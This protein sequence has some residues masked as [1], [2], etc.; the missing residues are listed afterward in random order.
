MRFLHDN[1]K[2][3]KGFT[4]IETVIGV[5]VFAIISL[6]IYQAYVSLFTLAADN[7]YTVL[8]L[9]LAN[10]EF[11]IARNLPFANVGE[12]SGIPSGSI[13]HVQNITNGGIPFVVTTTIRNIDIPFNGVQSIYPSPDSKLVEVQVGCPTC[14]NFSPVDLVTN[15]APKNLESATTTGA[16]FI[17]VFDANGIAVAGASVHVVDSKVSPSIVVDDTT[18]NTGM[19]EI[20]GAPP[21]VNAYNVTVSKT[22]YSSAKTYP[23]GGNGNP[24]PTQPDATVVVQQVTKISFSIDKLSTMSFQSVTPE[25]AS[26]GPVNFN[27]TGAKLI[28]ASLPKYS[29]NL[30]TGSGGSLNLSS[31]EWDSYTVAD[32]DSTYNIIGV[33]PLNPIA[34]NPNSSLSVMLVVQPKNPKSLLV[35]VKDSSTGLPITGATVTATSSGSYSNTQITGR[36]YLTQTDWSGGSGQDIFSNSAEYFSDDGNVEV[37]NPAGDIK[38]KKTS[39]YY[40]TTTVLESST[41]DTGSASNFY[42]LVWA[43]TSQPPQTGANS[44]KLQFATATSS[45]PSSWNYSGPDGTAGSYYTTANTVLNANNNGNR[46]ARYKVFLSTQN[47]TS[48]PDISDISFTFSSLCTPPGQVVFSGLSSGTY[49]ISVSHSGYSTSTASTSVSSNWT[50]DVVNLAP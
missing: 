40:A 48:T 4:L 43:P 19:L 28:G 2:L 34:L 35:T 29:Q 16:L 17:Q 31:M 11:E 37:A 44:V 32:L 38:L 9:N 6:A 12:V 3:R 18:D 30:S 47:S 45:E 14:A 26:V 41:F 23:P 8:A 24:N 5:A 13:P 39:G 20:L 49:N 27:L 36:G 1:V 33:N 22:G 42:N 25:C 21:G 10:Q 46:Y 7:Q 50:E 15:I